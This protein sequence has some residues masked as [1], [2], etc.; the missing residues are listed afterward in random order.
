MINIFKKKQTISLKSLPREMVFSVPLLF[1]FDY[2]KQLSNLNSKNTKYK[3]HSAYN[4]L[5]Y[6][7]YAKSGFEHGRSVN[8]QENSKILTLEDLR[9]YIQ[10]LDKNNIEFIY[11]MNSISTISLYDFESNI[12]QFKQFVS[13][14][15]DIGV[16][17]ITVGSQLL[18]DFLK[19]EFNGLSVNAS[20]M[21]DIRSIT[22]AKYVV[23]NLGISNIIP[24]SD[25]NKDFA[26]I[27]SF[28]KLFPETG[29]ELMA[30]EACIYGCPTKNIHYTLFGRQEN[31]HRCSPVF[32]EFPK[33][34]CDRI[35]GCNPAIQMVLNRIIYPWELTEL[36][37][38]GANSIKLVGRDHPKPELLNKIRAYMIGATDKEYALN[39][40]YNTY[41]SRFMNTAFSQYG[42][43]RMNK[44]IEYMPDINHFIKNKPQCSSQCGAACDY[45]FHKAALIEKYV[46]AKNTTNNLSC[47]AG[48]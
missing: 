2:I 34:I 4:S 25:L 3:I 17:S 40:F 33:F 39:E 42:T 27:E 43:L 22:Q 15:A 30:D 35:T 7:S 41:N 8:F 28:K 21:M 13:H 11:L 6:T 19:E 14:L 20:T 18:A 45:C 9:P 36:E 31:I 5:P 44:V 38:A 23:E 10:E 32:R 1:D 26:F 16:R 48:D 47:A 37:K 29:L 12:P 46:L 24:A